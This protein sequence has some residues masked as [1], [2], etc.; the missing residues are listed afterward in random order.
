MQRN[1]RLSAIVVAAIRRF[2]DEHGFVDVW[3][4][5]LTAATPEGARDF[6]CPFACSRAGSSPCL[7]RLRSSSRS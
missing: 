3:T 1:L 2:M 4:P 5:S 7:S 6:L